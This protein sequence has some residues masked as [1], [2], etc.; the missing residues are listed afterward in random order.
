M[1]ELILSL[2]S[3]YIYESRGSSSLLVHQL[4][5]KL[6]LHYTH[7]ANLQLTAYKYE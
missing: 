5:I 1:R 3:M 6:S 7:N 2:I 4:I